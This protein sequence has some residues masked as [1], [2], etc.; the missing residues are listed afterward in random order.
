MTKV[1]VPRITTVKMTLMTLKMEVEEDI[2]PD[3]R[4]TGR[5]NHRPIAQSL[6][7]TSAKERKREV[8]D[9]DKQMDGDDFFQT[10]DIEASEFTVLDSGKDHIDPE[11]LKR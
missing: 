1:S 2:T 6:P 8:G 3:G 10:K 5:S 11:S 7:S 4:N 9:G